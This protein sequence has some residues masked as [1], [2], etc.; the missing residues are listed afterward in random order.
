MSAALLTCVSPTQARVIRIVIDQTLNQPAIGG[1]QTVAYQTLNGRAFGELC[2]ANCVGAANNT[3]ITDLNLAPQV[4]S[5]SPAT[6]GATVVQYVSSFSIV[7]PADNTNISGILWH[8][9]P[10]RG[11]RIVINVAERGLGDVGLSSGWQGDNA[12][13]TAV[14]A[15]ASNTSPVTTGLV[16]NEWVKTPVL[17]VFSKTPRDGAIRPDTSTEAI[18]NDLI[19]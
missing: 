16:N 11:G 1:A 7:K 13:A 4:A 12:G 19:P 3:I 9:V 15:Y 5:T 8:D 18:L 2:I 17:V 14:P 10:N 6:P